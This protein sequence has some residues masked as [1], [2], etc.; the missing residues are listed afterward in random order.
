[1]H[2]QY[3]A[4]EARQPIF[5]GRLYRAMEVLN[6][7]K[8]PPIYFWPLLWGPRT[9]QVCLWPDTERLKMPNDLFLVGLT[10]DTLEQ[11]PPYASRMFSFRL[12]T[13]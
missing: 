7:R 3:R 4:G 6:R 12:L 13:S 8:S 11:H 5:T 10:R 9:A 2:L 1:M